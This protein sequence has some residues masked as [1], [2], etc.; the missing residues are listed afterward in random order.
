[1][2]LDE[3]IKEFREA[4]ENR[5]PRVTTKHF[6]RLHA[7]EIRYC[8]ITYVCA[9]K[10]NT[11]YTPHNWP[12]AARKLELSINDANKIMLASDHFGITTDDLTQTL[13]GALP[14]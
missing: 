12:A 14:Q 6:I 3:F 10:T 9:V 11:T 8:P 2:T 7:N 13:L 4:I 5:K 1:M